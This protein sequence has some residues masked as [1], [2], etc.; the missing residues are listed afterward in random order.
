[1]AESR[2]P[3]LRLKLPHVTNQTSAHAPAMLSHPWPATL[4]TLALVVAI[5]AAALC[6]RGLLPA[7]ATRFKKPLVAGALLVASLLVLFTGGVS[8]SLAT[9][10][11]AAWGMAECFGLAIGAAGFLLAAASA[12]LALTGRS[13]GSVTIGG[14]M[15]AATVGALPYF[16]ARSLAAMQARR[17]RR[18]TRL[19]AHIARPTPT[20]PMPTEALKREVLLSVERTEATKD[21]ATLDGLLRDVRD[22]LQADEAIFWRWSEDRD[23]LLPTAWSTEESAR[24]QFFRVKDWGPLARWSARE[25]IVTFDGTD[26]APSLVA[27]PVIGGSIED[28]AEMLHG[29]ITLSRDSGLALSRDAVKAWLPRFAAQLSAYLDLFDMRTHYARNSRRNQALIE[30]LERLQVHKSAEAL[31]SAVCETAL[32]VTSGK[33]ALLIRWLSQDAYGLVQYASRELA[34]EPG[35][36]IGKDTLVGR[37]CRDGMPL[38]LHDARAV[39]RSDPAYTSTLTYRPI[40]SLVVVPIVCDQR[41]IGAIVVEGAEPASIGVEEARNVGLLAGVARAFLEKVWEI[42]DVSQRAR[43]DALTGLANRREFDEQLRRVLAETDRFGGTSSLIVVDIDLFKNVNDMYGHEAGD[44]VLRQVGK[45]LGDGVRAVDI[46]ARYGG[47]EMAILLP[48]TPISGASEL[49]ERLRSAIADRAVQFEGTSIRV[50]ASFGIAGYPETVPHGDWLFPAADK[51]L[52]QAKEGGRNCV[53]SLTTSD[54]L[55]SR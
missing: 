28:Q 43:T 37:T 22:L 19:E 26:D 46:C 24:P 12:T 16:Y 6:I 54:G 32:E 29:V 52:Y 45:I 53:K 48:Q 3:A 17:D 8:S 33:S 11:I 25:R 35:M 4:S 7:S 10:G 27:A 34:L 50:T 47:E 41:V 1:M 15:L 31:G 9:V 44:A 23:T 42:E 13:P 55:P 2:R 14:A 49:A 30:A 5:A 36:I 51:A 38:L 21:L 40:P 18:V 39:T 20:R